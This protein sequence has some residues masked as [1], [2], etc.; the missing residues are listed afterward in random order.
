MRAPAK[1]SCASQVVIR[2]LVRRRFGLFGAF[3]AAVTS[4]ALLAFS[5]ARM[6]GAGPAWWSFPLAAMA[7]SVGLA[8]VWLVI[9]PWVRSE[10]PTLRQLEVQGASARTVRLTV[11]AVTGGFGLFSTVLSLAL[12]LFAREWLESAAGL[13]SP[14]N[15]TSPA[16]FLACLYGSVLLLMTLVTALAG[17]LRQTR[18]KERV[19]ARMVWGIAT[20]IL[21]LEAITV[22]SQR[23]FSLSAETFT[24]GVVLLVLGLAIA[25][26]AFYVLFAR[27]FN[28]IF[29]HFRPGTA[30]P[31]SS[32]PEDTKA[33]EAA[34]AM[35]LAL[36]LAVAV[37]V[38][39]READPTNGLQW[40]WAALFVGTYAV[41]V[42]LWAVW[43]LTRGAS[44]GYEGL[45]GLGARAITVVGMALR[46]S[47]LIAFFQALAGLLVG[48]GM[49]AALRSYTGVEGMGSS[50]S[51]WPFALAAA[52]ASF[53]VCVFVWVLAAVAA[54]KRP[55][56]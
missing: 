48:V 11:A 36:A 14:A 50:G 29:F 20:I 31:A 21:A 5:L 6:W 49:A 15:S 30:T 54:P 45:W 37:L 23:W 3:L 39:P 32:W 22:G 34:A 56:T 35:A 44:R 43:P 4:S 26:P 55:R 47:L 17:T 27:L 33:G 40:Q 46:Q 1:K 7:V 24:L 16:L 53:V 12:L 13:D 52:G 51:L 9:R 10:A 41:A 42:S 25:L 2:S 19:P 18:R 28:D 38:G 8:Q